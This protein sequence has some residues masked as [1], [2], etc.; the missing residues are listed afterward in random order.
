MFTLLLDRIDHAALCEALQ[1]YL[2]NSD[3]EEMGDDR[4]IAQMFPELK[5]KR[6]AAQ[7]ILTRLETQ[8]LS[9]LGLL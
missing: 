5:E 6:E 9:K 8:M 7:K 1:Q 2:D 4:E 3:P